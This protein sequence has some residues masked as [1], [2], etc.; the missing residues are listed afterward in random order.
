MDV[1]SNGR[2]PPFGSLQGRAPKYQQTALP[3]EQIP[4]NVPD[5]LER[6]LHSNCDN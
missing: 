6:D 2:E 5:V 1:S 3:C 4:T